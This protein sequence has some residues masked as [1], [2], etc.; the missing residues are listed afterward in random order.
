MKDVIE[1][2]SG[3]KMKM[4]RASVQVIAYEDCELLWLRNEGVVTD[5]RNISKL[6]S[7]DLRR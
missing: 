3:T 6:K 7:I 1:K 5:K 2:R 4:S